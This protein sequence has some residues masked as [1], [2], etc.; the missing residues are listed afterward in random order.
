MHYTHRVHARNKNIL[1]LVDLSSTEFYPKP[2]VMNVA[3]YDAKHLRKGVLVGFKGL[4]KPANLHYARDNQTLKLTR[5][6][7]LPKSKPDVAPRFIVVKREGSVIY[8]KLLTKEDSTV[9]RHFEDETAP[10]VTMDLE[11]YA[12]R[13]IHKRITFYFENK[14]LP[15]DIRFYTHNRLEPRKLERRTY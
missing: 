9:K 8:Y 15:G 2:L 13:C 6:G 1:F 10:I 12:Y 11:G 14:H 3:G 4:P 5:V 7:E